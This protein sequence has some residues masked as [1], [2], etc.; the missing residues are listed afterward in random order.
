MFH[1]NE[2]QIEEALAARQQLQAEFM[3][4][5]T[6]LINELSRKRQN[7]Q[8]KLTSYKK[9]LQ[10]M[11]ELTDRD[12]QIKKQFDLGYVDSLS[13]I[14]SKSEIEKAKQA[15]FAIKIDVLRAMEQLEQITQ[16]PMDQ[17][18]DIKTLTHNIVE[19]DK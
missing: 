3:Q 11:D 17:K 2:G 19:Q 15:V 8:D 5:Q 18:I 16:Q 10:L 12:K 9:A 13:V 4:L 14:R 7:Y 1:N 6:S